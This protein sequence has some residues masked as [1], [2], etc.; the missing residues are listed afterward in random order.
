MNQ[1]IFEA[2]SRVNLTFNFN[3]SLVG[4]YTLWGANLKG[5]ALTNHMLALGDYARDLKGLVNKTEE[6]EFT[7][8]ATRRTKEQELNKLRFDVVSHIFSTLKAEIEAAKVKEETAKVKEKDAEVFKQI[9]L[10]KRKAELQ[11]TAGKMSKEELEKKLAELM[12]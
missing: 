1:N 8:V 7:L 3:N 11:E 9:L 5:I 2:A 4:I 12:S 6:D 10:D